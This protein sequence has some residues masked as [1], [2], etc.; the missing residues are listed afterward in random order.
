MLFN[1]QFSF[2]LLNIK[3]SLSSMYDLREGVGSHPSQMG[4]GDE[5]ENSGASRYYS[6]EFTYFCSCFSQFNVSL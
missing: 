5:N 2:V 1:F 4:A 3:S 6:F